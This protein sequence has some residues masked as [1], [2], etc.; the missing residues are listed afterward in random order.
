MSLIHKVC[1]KTDRVKKYFSYFV[2]SDVLAKCTK[3][4]YYLVLELKKKNLLPSDLLFLG[5][6]TR[7]VIGKVGVKHAAVANFLNRVAHCASYT[8]KV[9][10]R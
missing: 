5:G 2:N 8:E 3:P 4:P 7:K 9:V 1:L 10:F 6:K